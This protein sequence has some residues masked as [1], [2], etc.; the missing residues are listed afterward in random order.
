MCEYNNHVWLAKYISEGGH[1]EPHE[2]DL[3]ECGHV[4]WH[5]NE[6]GKPEPYVN[7]RV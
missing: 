3:C 2:G 4:V 6:N 1:A 7:V 5:I